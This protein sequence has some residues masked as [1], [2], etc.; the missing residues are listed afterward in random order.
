MGTKETVIP[1]DLQ[2]EEAVLGALILDRHDRD[3]ALSIL[4]QGCFYDTTC[5]LVYQTVSDL[6]STGEEVDMYTVSTALMD[7][8]NP[9][10]VVELT[11]RIASATSL[12]KHCRKLYELH[13]R[14]EYIRI[15]QQLQAR[16]YSQSVDVE[17]IMSDAQGD[18]L[19]LLKFDTANVSTID[20]VV[21]QVFGIMLKNAEA[22]S[23]LSG[24]GTGLSELDM[25]TGGLQ[26][27]DLVIVAGE[28]SQ[29][30]T[31]LALT[32]ANNAALLYD[33]RVAFYSLEMGNTQL[34]ARL[35][36][37][38]TGVSGKSI[39]THRL[40]RGL[41][42]L[43]NS[44]TSKLCS[45]KIYFDDSS[46]TGIDSILRSIRAMKAKYDINLV[47]VD[48]LQL[49]TCRTKGASREQQ[50]GEVA[51]ALKNVAKELNI[52]VI[53][54]SQLSRSQTPKPTLNRLRDS[55]QIEEA[56][57]VI[58]LTYR[59]EAY[60]LEYDDE[61]KGYNPTG[62]ALIDVAKGRSIG[63]HKFV[64]SFRKE[65]TLF[66]DYDGGSYQPADTDF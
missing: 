34:A 15:G 57:D 65:L 27:S 33:A 56:A 54:L 66:K 17:E 55:G 4:N 49:V 22:A 23:P 43:I 26:P 7:K 9:V 41:I 13:M 31:S 40:D 61:L 30:K 39:L 16:A 51:R 64:L 58:L 38:Q 47:V 53:A 28:T 48:F 50:V 1:H 18:M 36:A 8:V 45:A 6:S 5:R 46:T 11:Q 60:G 35:M 2:L 3:E 25:H 59:P 63:T 14:R 44:N 19:K 37:Q 21:D 29:G 42:Q 12:L 32:I 62:S 10:K 52:C 24:I 20:S